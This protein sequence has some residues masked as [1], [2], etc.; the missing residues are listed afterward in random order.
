MEKIDEEI[1][2]YVVPDL[3]PKLFSFRFIRWVWRNRHLESSLPILKRNTG[4]IIKANV[5]RSKLLG[6]TVKQ[7]LRNSLEG[8]EAAKSVLDQALL[9]K[10]PERLINGY[11][12]GSAMSSQGTFVIPVL[13][14]YNSINNEKF[15]ILQNALGPLRFFFQYKR[16]VRMLFSA[17]MIYHVNL[18][19][20]LLYMPI[21][22]YWPSPC[23]PVNIW[24]FKREVLIVL[25]LLGEVFG[26]PY[27]KHPILLPSRSMTFRVAKNSTSRI[28]NNVLKE[29]YFQK[30]QYLYKERPIIFYLMIKGN[31][32][33]ILEEVLTSDIVGCVIET[34]LNDFN[35]TTISED[36]K[37][38]RLE[39]EAKAKR[40]RDSAIRVLLF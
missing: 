1:I 14:A 2:G 40:I 33:F 16:P 9:N 31:L 21:S 39:S 38:L 12:F 29:Q 5:K 27:G 13:I 4:L 18:S 23:C 25:A 37:T 28:V 11:I 35:K 26:E 36:R 3:R 32:D 30:E 6:L 8:Y 7:Y 22:N 24:R 20:L 34:S 19:I 17:A 15:V 10:L